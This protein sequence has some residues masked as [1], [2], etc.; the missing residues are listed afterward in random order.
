MSLTSHSVLK[1]SIKVPQVLPKGQGGISE[2]LLE[3]HNKSK[4]NLKENKTI[5]SKT[6]DS[7]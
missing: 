2:V 3:N 1:Q 7:R 5:S 4:K 6:V